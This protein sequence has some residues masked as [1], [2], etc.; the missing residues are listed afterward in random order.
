[1]ALVI[2]YMSVPQKHYTWKITV[3]KYTAFTDLNQMINN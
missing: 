3:N 2:K 1:M